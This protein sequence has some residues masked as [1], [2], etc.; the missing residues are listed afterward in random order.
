ML[1]SD[2]SPRPALA[3]NRRRHG[4]PKVAGRFSVEHSAAIM[5]RATIVR[6]A[7]ALFLLVSCAHQSLAPEAV[8]TASYREASKALVCAGGDAA[9]CAEKAAAARSAGTD[10][11]RAA[12]LWYAVAMACPQ[13]RDEASRAVLAPAPAAA[14]PTIN[15]NYRIRLSPAY[16]LYW[17]AASAGPRLL[18]SAGPA[19]SAE[20]KVQAVRFDRGQPGP[21]LTTE[22]RFEFPADPGATVTIEV[23]EA[24]GTL[25]LRID[26]QRPPT[27]HPRPVNP[28]PAGP[29]PI[30]EKPQLVQL[31]PSRVPLEFE[32]FMRGAHPVVRLCLDRQGDL[33]TIRFL[34]PAHPRL[35][36]TVIDLFRDSRYQPY[37][38]NDLA[39]PSC[40]VAGP[41]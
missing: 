13:A 39:V 5:G 28:K 35:A 25:D 7:G 14:G 2:G 41:S 34:A 15:V 33:D 18:P 19:P 30:L 8:E 11:V 22:K 29:A 3:Q 36:A 6:G 4:G 9:C 20:V 26:V 1:E 31:G 40:E 32:P 37:R 24:R 27:P 17:V 21:L 23:T 16:R 10:T 12:Q 38:V